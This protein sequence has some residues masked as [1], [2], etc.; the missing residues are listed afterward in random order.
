MVR[1]CTVADLSEH[2]MPRH[3]LRIEPIQRHYSPQRLECGDDVTAIGRPAEAAPPLMP[4]SRET[5]ASHVTSSPESPSANG[6]RRASL[7]YHVMGS[8]RAPR[9]RMSKGPRGATRKR[10]RRRYTL[11]G[12]TRKR[13]GRPSLPRRGLLPR[14]LPGRRTGNITARQNINPVYFPFLFMGNQYER[15]FET[16]HPICCLK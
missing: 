11:N 10:K 14:A 5:A 13:K 3:P 1:T 7:S 16:Q 6:R 12:G 8:R 4:P 2:R 9:K 15:P